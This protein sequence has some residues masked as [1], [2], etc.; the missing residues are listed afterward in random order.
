MRDIRNNRFFFGGHFFTL[1][2]D[3]YDYVLG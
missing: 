3:F 2:R 1:S